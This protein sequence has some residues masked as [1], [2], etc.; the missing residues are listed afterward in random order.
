MCGPLGGSPVECGVVGQIQPYKTPH[1]PDTGYHSPGMTLPR[2]AWL[3]L[4]CLRTGVGPFLSCLHK[5]SMG[6]CTA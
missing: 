4:N 6:D 1:F 2:T 5:W 3:R